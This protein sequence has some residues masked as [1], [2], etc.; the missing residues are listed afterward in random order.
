MNEIFFLSD[1]FWIQDI[2]ILYDHNTYLLLSRVS[3]TCLIDLYR[4][5]TE[6]FRP[7][8]FDNSDIVVYMNNCSYKR[9]GILFNPNKVYRDQIQ[10]T[11]CLCKSCVHLSLCI[12]RMH[13]RYADV[14]DKKVNILESTF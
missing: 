7:V 11:G 6:H 10:R 12:S 5:M 14:L 13:V 3:Q 9:K 2:I 4:K 1:I 8:L